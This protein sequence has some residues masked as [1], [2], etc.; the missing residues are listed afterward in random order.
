MI[1]VHLLV[2]VHGNWMESRQRHIEMMVMVVMVSWDAVDTILVG[3]SH[4]RCSNRH[5]AD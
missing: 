1:R 5:Y 2:G 4:G 3:R